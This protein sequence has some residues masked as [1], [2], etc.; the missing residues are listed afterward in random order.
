MI[1]TEI[2]EILE[3]KIANK[4]T[5]YN[6][7]VE[8][9]H[10]APSILLTQQMHALS[11]IHKNLRHCLHN[12]YQTQLHGLS[13]KQL[14]QLAHTISMITTQNTLGNN[15]DF[16]NAAGVSSYCNV[17]INSTF[18]QPWILH[19][20]VTDHITTYLILF[21]KINITSISLLIYPMDLR[22][23]TFTLA[24]SYAIL[25]SP[26]KKFYVYYFFA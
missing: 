10:V 18:T 12:L 21:T 3:T 8:A 24:P 7:N 16:A 14:Q 4:T 13:L 17:S 25:L 15:N 6:S 2:K 20:G 9:T 19:N 26:Q 1:D 23:L 11:F 5:N 22:F